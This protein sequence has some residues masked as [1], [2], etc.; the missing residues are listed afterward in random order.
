MKLKLWEKSFLLT[1]IVFFLILNVCLVMWYMFDTKSDYQKFADDCMNDA[2]NILYLENQIDRGS[3]GRVEIS[4]MAENYEEKGVY[5]RFS[6]SGN[7]LTDN[8]PDG[9]DLAGESISIG[10]IDVSGV[11]YYYI[12]SGF[13][14]CRLEYMK[15][16]EDVYER[17]LNM[18][19]MIVLIDVVM[20]FIVGILLYVAMRKI[21]KPVSDISH[22]LRTP[23]TS[24]LGYAQYLSFDG[25]SDEEKRAV[26][27]RI[28]TEAKYMKDIVERLLTVDSLRGKNIVSSRID[29]ERLVDELSEKYPSMSFEN[30]I[31]TINGDESL[32]KMLLINIIE[33][34]VREDLAAEFYADGSII[35][36]I[37]RAENLTVEDVYKMNSGMHIDDSKIKGN[38]IGMELCREIVKAHEWDIRYELD[39]GRLIANVVQKDR[40]KEVDSK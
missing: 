5:I 3:V 11:D 12:E 35:K 24:I 22:E 36:V 34:A 4:E 26:V 20:A 7:V 9:F 31:R 29:F 23:L 28:E 6:F 14:D 2:E 30:N 38:G 13:N 16:M 18:A 17:N 37:N 27:Y 21:Y 39:N 1:F 40:R 25:V 19:W 8:L 10:R 15:S 33:N 32:V